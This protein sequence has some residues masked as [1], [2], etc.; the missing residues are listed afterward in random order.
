MSFR[1]LPYLLGSTALLLGARSAATQDKVRQPTLQEQLDTWYRAA[2]R[3]A[4]G[5]W[6]IAVADVQGRLVWGVQPT[7]PLIPASTVKL[8]TT[9]FARSIVGG[10]ARK[11]TRVVGNGQLDPASGA[12]NG[13]WAL[14]LNGDPTLEHGGGPGSTS[15]SEL[16][17]QL[18]TRGIR[19]LTGPLTVTSS[20]GRPEASF[21]S[22]WSVRHRGRYFAPLVGNLTI[23][24]NLIA[25]TIA[26]AAKVGRPVQL[27]GTEPAGVDALFDVKARTVN[28]RRS[29]LRVEPQRD[30]RYLI[31][32]TMGSRARARTLVRAA[33]DVQTLLGASWRSALADAGIEWTPASGVGTKAGMP[34]VLAEV[35]SPVFDSIASEVNRRSLNLGAEL[36]L[37]WG[38]GN[39]SVPADKLTAH[40][41]EITGDYTGVKLVD[42]SG[43]SDQNRVSPWTFVSYLARFPQAPGGRNFPMLLPAN[44]S[45]TLWT[46]ANGLPER[47]VVRAKT[48]TLGNVATLVGYLGRPDG[49]LLVSLMYNGHRIHAAR[50]AQWMLFRA[51]GADGVVI[52]PDSADTESLGGEEKPPER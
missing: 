7:R 22:T 26:P 16:A 29:R 32:G 46:L 9:G 36:L 51:L 50:Q 30:G 28:G 15:L 21:P 25:A 12:W 39:D 35:H 52:P 10:D 11:A 6:G 42:G 18:A 8:L 1:V 14:E 27:I 13:G 5:Q 40:V 23:H 45:G 24:D 49:V 17:S 4:P 43:L 19:R 20:E 2:A 38:A 41:R 31:A 37:K 48:G 34:L 47:G 33:T 3:R 44:G